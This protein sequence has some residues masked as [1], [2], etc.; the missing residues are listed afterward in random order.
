MQSGC[1]YITVRLIKFFMCFSSSWY[2]AAPLSPECPPPCP[3]YSRSSPH[4]FPHRS[5]I[6][7]LESDSSTVTNLEDLA[8]VVAQPDLIDQRLLNIL[9]ITHCLAPLELPGQSVSH[10]TPGSTVR[11]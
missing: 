1:P 2:R 7:L 5:M 4:S 11:R 6:Q 3:S 10:S 9:L 8:P